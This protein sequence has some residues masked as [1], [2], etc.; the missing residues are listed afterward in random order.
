MY[1]G[2][3]NYRSYDKRREFNFDVVNYPDIN[4]N[5]P[6]KPSYGIFTSQLTRFSLI[7]KTSKYFFKD[8]KLLVTKL[9]HKNFNMNILKNKYLEFAK[10]K[11][12]IWSKFGDDITANNFTRDIFNMK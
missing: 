7:N 4:G 11:I 8:I 6:I 12:N 9:R 5:V 2:Q 3:F 10:H 1:G